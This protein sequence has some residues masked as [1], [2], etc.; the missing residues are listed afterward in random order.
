M[1]FTNKIPEWKNEGTEPS[2]TLK[3]DGFQAGYKPPASIFNWFWSK[4]TKT[5]NEIQGVFKSHTE[6]KENPHSVTKSQVGLGNVPNVATN[7]QTPTYSDTTTLATL[8]SGE[9]LNVALQKIKCAITN[10]ISHIGN[11]SNPHG[12]TASQV[13]AL[14][15]AGGKLT[16]NNLNF[17]DNGKIGIDGNGAILEAYKSDGD[18]KNRR[19]LGIYDSTYKTNVKDAFM[20]YDEVGGTYT[21]FHIYGEHNK[22]SASDVGALALNGGVMTGQ[23]FYINNKTGR[24]VGNQNGMWLRTASSDVDNNEDARHLKLWNGTYV[25]ELPRAMCLYDNKTGKD[26]II[27]GQHNVTASTTDLIAGTSPLASGAIHLVYE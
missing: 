5:I 7:D 2:D 18:T 15:I 25:T 6:N 17:N 3:N 4:V 13:G 9:K 26:Y 23:G 8:N 14:P 16:G 20:L 10:L 12:V 1:E 22:P 21:Q 11:K 24:I 27:Y 19:G